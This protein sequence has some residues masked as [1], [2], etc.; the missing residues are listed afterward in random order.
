[1]AEQFLGVGFDVHGG[2]SDLVFPHHENEAAQTRAA[3]G[4]ELAQLW[5]HNG[6]IQSTGEKMAK[7]VG[8][9]A[10]LHEELAR[11]SAQALVMYL[12]P[13]HY[14][15]PLA[16]SQAELDDADRRVQRIREAL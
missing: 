6:M 11:H 3:R 14:R 5:M 13:G 15:Q 7:S 8:N 2:G 4:T 1:M 9:I 16:F 10:P 12:I